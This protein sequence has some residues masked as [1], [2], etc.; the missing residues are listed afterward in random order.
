M[1]TYRN[2]SSES[3]GNDYFQISAF[4]KQP[5][6]KY[7][8]L[9][10]FPQLQKISNDPPINND[11]Q[12]IFTNVNS[13]T[14]A[15]PIYTFNRRRIIRIENTSS[16]G[17]IDDQIKIQCFIGLTDD[18]Q[19]FIPYKELIFNLK[20]FKNQNGDDIRLWKPG[21]DFYIDP[22]KIDLIVE[23][24]C[25]QVIEFSSSGIINVLIK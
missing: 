16:V 19:T 1:P 14:S 17:S 2:T 21:E 24:V 4:C 7:I 22:L 20:G 15:S 23:F 8:S 12:P 13:I 6:K 3:I 11:F 10:E 18:I 25:F 5:V 9:F